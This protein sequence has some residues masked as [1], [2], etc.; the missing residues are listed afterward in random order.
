MPDLPEWVLDLVAVVER[1]EY[2]HPKVGEGLDACLGE[3]LNQVPADVRA[4]A[5]GWARARRGQ[6]ATD[7]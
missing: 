5:R 1:F 7:A 4:E 6:G 2:V 3:A